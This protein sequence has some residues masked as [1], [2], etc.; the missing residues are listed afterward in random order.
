MTEP[1]Y[2]WAVHVLGRSP[3]VNHVSGCQPR[4]GATPLLRFGLPPLM[5]WSGRCWLLGVHQGSIPFVLCVFVWPWLVFVV[6]VVLAL[7]CGVVGRWWCPTCV[8]CVLVVVVVHGWV[9]R[10]V[11]LAPALGIGCWASVGVCG[12]FCGCPPPLWCVAVLCSAPL[13]TSVGS[14]L[15]HCVVCCAASTRNGGHGYTGHGHT[16]LRGPS[17]GNLRRLGCSH[18][19]VG[20][21]GSK[22]PGPTDEN[23]TQISSMR[24]CGL[25]VPRH[26][27]VLYCFGVCCAALSAPACCDAVCAMLCAMLHQQKNGGH[28]YTGHG[29]SLP[30]GPSP[31]N[32][33]ST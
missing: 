10:V 4:A 30:W 8:P 24:L 6:G 25:C 15:P 33:R 31:G 11:G 32:L 14:S 21:A 13:C 1:D 16:L 5:V 12:V 3:M 17:S 28:G 18:K 2:S 19:P 29:H 9:A 23:C 22:H 20:R 26:Y 7:G 27:A